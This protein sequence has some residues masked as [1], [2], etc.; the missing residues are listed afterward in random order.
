MIR[1][2]TSLARVEG[3]SEQV[4]EAPVPRRRSPVSK[5]SQNQLA[6]DASPPSSPRR[7]VSPEK[8]G[9]IQD[10][11]PVYTRACWYNRYAH[12]RRCPRS[13]SP[14][15]IRLNIRST[16]VR[17]RHAIGSFISPS[18][19]LFGHLAKAY[20]RYCRAFRKFG[21]YSKKS[22]PLQLETTACAS[23]TR[24][25]PTPISNER[26]PNSVD[27][28]TRGSFRCRSPPNSTGGGGKARQSEGQIV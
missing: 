11:D 27:F 26:F 14:S 2:N 20:K 4:S 5:T 13:R 28:R 8:N 25:A 16:A 18:L 22:L 23:L 12:K 6:L 24:V 7:F 9:A 21:N 15:S 3:L 17:F 1:R 19:C 10:Q